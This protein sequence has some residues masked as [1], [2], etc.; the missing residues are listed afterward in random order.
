[1]FTS[2]GYRVCKKKFK[3][4]VFRKAYYLPT[5]TSIPAITEVR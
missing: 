3:D 4:T 5:S 2:S 1:M